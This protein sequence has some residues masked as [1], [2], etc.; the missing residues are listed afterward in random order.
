MR[1]TFEMRFD[2]L[3]PEPWLASFQAGEEIRVEIGQQLFD[4]MYHITTLE[5]TFH[6]NTPRFRSR[7]VFMR[8]GPLD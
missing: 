2:E 3:P 1:F 4:G 7:L 5:I 8:T 6:E